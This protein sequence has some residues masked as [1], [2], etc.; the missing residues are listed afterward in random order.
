M[1]RRDSLSLSR[2]VV[3]SLLPAILLLLVL[4]ASA[5]FIC[6]SRFEPYQTDI[7]TQGD[8]RWVSHPTL[9]WTNRPRYLEYDKSSQYNEYGMR[10]RPGE[11]RLPQ[12]E[13]GEIWVFC[14]GGSAMAGVGSSQEGDWLKISGVP[15][16]PIADSIDGYLE[17]M[18][19]EALSE[20]KVRVFNASVSGHSVLQSRLRYEELRHLNPDWIISMDGVNEPST[21]KTGDTIRERLAARWE[22]HPVNN[23]PFQQ[24]RFLMR[25]SAALFLLGEHIFY[26]TGIIRSPRNIN[27]DKEVM[28]FWLQKGPAPRQESGGPADPDQLRAADV[29][30]KTLKDFQQTLARERQKYLLL[31]QPHLTLR[32]PTGLGD[33]EKALYNYYS[34]TK[35]EA[36]DTFMRVVDER[37]T[38]DFEPTSGIFSMS[39][40]HYSSEWIFVDYCHLTSEANKIIAG[41]LSRYILS[42]GGYRPFQLSSIGPENRRRDGQSS[43]DREAQGLAFGDASP[44]PTESAPDPTDQ[45]VHQRAP[46]RGRLTSGRRRASMP[47]AVG[48]APVP[49]E[50]ASAAPAGESS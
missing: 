20:R 14:L 48:S 27:R 43:V 18:L 45:R 24:A 15:T 36:A 5:R 39:S 26:K 35:E 17:S 33:V 28:R 19:Q 42:E 7:R 44:P 3:Y 16:H 9:I 37:V 50:G 6:R 41:E 46:P 2:R 22:R 4:E 40:L 31:V 8:S 47:A 25:N 23:S 1:E 30:I 38:V 12:R 49:P 10:T 13:P 34:H 21:L 29:F 32:D 11:V